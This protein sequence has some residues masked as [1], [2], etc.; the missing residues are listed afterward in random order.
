MHKLVR[1][2]G[3]GAPNVKGITY[4]KLIF[5]AMIIYPP[6]PTLVLSLSEIGDLSC[7]TY[8][9]VLHGFHMDTLLKRKAWKKERKLW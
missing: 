8:C 6:D 2:G 1:N 3:V 5:F 4:F 9:L 7:I